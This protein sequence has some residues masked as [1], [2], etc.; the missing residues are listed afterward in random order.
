[1]AGRINHRGWIVIESISSDDSGLCV[2]FFNDPAGGFGFEHLRADPE[3]GGRWTAI[4]GYSGARYETGLAAAAAALEAVHWLGRDVAASR[5]FAQ[6]K[7][8]LESA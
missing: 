4:G 1:M 8:R 6:W 7:A 2:D 3:D 5:A